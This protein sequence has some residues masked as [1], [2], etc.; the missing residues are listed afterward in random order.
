MISHLRPR[1]KR[2]PR[3]LSDFIIENPFILIVIGLIQMR[4][5]IFWP[6]VG[7]KP[8]P[9]Y[10]IPITKDNPNGVISAQSYFYFIHEYLNLIFVWIFC[11]LTTRYKW[12]MILAIFLEAVDIL[13]YCLRYNQKLMTVLRWDLDY[14]DLKIL[15]YFAIFLTTWKLKQLLR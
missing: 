10:D 6:D 11:F 13:D 12:Q 8:F 2:L 15:L 5:F 4:F 7:W 9:Y 14:T 3:E 1:L